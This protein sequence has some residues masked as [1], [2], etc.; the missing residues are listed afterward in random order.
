MSDYK[1][2]LIR[3]LSVIRYRSLAAVEL[4]DLPPVV[5]LYGPNGAGKSN[6]LRAAQLVL[7]AAAHPGEMPTKREVALSLPLPEADRQLGLRPDD[8]R[9]G[10]QPEIRVSVEIELG[11]RAAQMALPPAGTTLGPLRLEAVFQRVGDGAIRFWFERT[12]V[13]GAITLGPSG[14]TQ[15]RGLQNALANLRNN[16]ANYEAQRAALEGQLALLDSQG[17]SPQNAGQRAQ[18]KASLQQTTQQIATARTQTATYEAGLGDE[19]MVAERIRNVLLPRLL[20]VSPAYR[21]P[22]GTDD[23]E[24]ALYRAFLSEDEAE[25]EAAWR[26]SRRL[27]RVRLFGD[28]CDSLALSPVNSRTYG[29]MQVRFHHPTHGKLSMRNLGSGEQQVVFMLGQRVITPSPIA[30]LEEPEAHLHKK[31]MEPF[32]RLLQ[33][34]VSSGAENP[35]VDQIW[36]ATHHRYF[37]IGDRFLDVSLDS[38]GATQV[39]WKKRDEVAEH[40]YEPSPYLATLRTLAESGLSPDTV[41]HRDEDGGPILLRDVLASI[42]GDGELA[43]KFVEAATKAFVLSITEPEPEP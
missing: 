18:L 41:V 15:K 40:L 12:D 32:A 27:A 3:N 24:A 11:T 9:F 1:R 8:F 34:S 23:P 19:A 38:N 10:D 2:T 13:D 36:I 33:E 14:D 22:G 16:T 35:D 39:A 6:I 21:V 28:R 17:Y 42:D 4:A 26:L 20:Q 37:G 31:L 30:H 29:E 7:R 25:S 43:R 5:V